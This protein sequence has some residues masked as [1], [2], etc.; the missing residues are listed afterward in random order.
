MSDEKIFCFIIVGL[1]FVY[2]IF[3]A[4]ADFKSLRDS[5]KEDDKNNEVK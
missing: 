3:H 4:I 2:G 5:A 1:M